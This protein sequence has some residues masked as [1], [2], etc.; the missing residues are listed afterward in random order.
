MNIYIPSKSRPNVQRTY[1]HLPP[2]LR[3]KTQMVVPEE[4]AV[5]YGRN[6][7]AD[8]ILV[9][10]LRG[11]APTRDAIV[12]QARGLGQDKIVMLD[13]DLIFQRFR[14]DGKITNCTPDEVVQAFK[15]L[16]MTLDT[17]VHAGFAI[18]FSD[19][20]GGYLDKSPGRMMHVLGYNINRLPE[21]A[22]FW[23]GVTDYGTFS[24]DDF[25]MTLQ[26]LTRGIPN[27]VSGEWRTSPSAGNSKGGASTWRNL[28]TQN[29]SAHDL[30]RLFPQ[31]VALR[32]KN[33]WQ[34]IEGGQM[35]DVTVQWKRAYGT[36]R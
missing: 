20:G 33:N 35:Y 21:D 36:N 31:Y 28:Q 25:N 34:G 2:V 5:A 22:T 12:Q 14:A 19:K 29:Q 3:E 9:C 32:S 8:R 16:E 4:D 26:L 27:V 13:D 15:W 17:Y 10:P 11:I 30:A 23:R 18:R 6:Y 1:D 24:M 7:G